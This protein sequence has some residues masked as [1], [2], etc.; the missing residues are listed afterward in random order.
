ML[1]PVLDS[2]L[3]VLCKN[4]TKKKNSFPKDLTVSALSSETRRVEGGRMVLQRILIL[5]SLVE[6]K[7]TLLKEGKVSLT[8]IDNKKFGKI[9]QN[10]TH[11]AGLKQILNTSFCI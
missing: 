5:P 6:K 11:M 7:G 4:R 8:R 2:N 9:L 10:F 1:V 3:F